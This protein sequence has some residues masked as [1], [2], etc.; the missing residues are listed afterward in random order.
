MTTAIA[1]PQGAQEVLFAVRGGSWIAPGLSAGSGLDWLDAELRPVDGLHQAGLDW[2]VPYVEPMQGVIDRMAGKASVIRSFVDSW[3]QIATT[4]GQAG[5]RL[6]QKASAETSSWLGESADNYRTWAAWT[7]GAAGEGAV[8]ATATGEAARMMGEVAGSARKSVD[9]LVTNLVE[10]LASAVPQAVAAEGGVTP[11]VL[12]QATTLVDSYRRPVADIERNLKTTVENLRSNL[13]SGVGG[14][15]DEGTVASRRVV[16][17]IAMP[18]SA[19]VPAGFK[20]PKGFGG[21]KPSQ[22]GPSQPPRQGPGGDAES[23]WEKLLPWRRKKPDSKN[24]KP[25]RDPHDDLTPQEREQMRNKIMDEYKRVDKPENRLSQTNAEDALK[26][27]PPGTKIEV[28]GDKAD[29][30]WKNPDGTTAAGR[31]LKV[32]EGVTPDALN[33]RLSNAKDQLAEVQGKREVWVQLQDG[34]RLTK[35]DLPKLMSDWRNSPNRT[36]QQWEPY[37]GIEV[38]FRDAMGR[39]LGRFDAGPARP[40]P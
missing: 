38:T 13:V 28:G 11:N 40:I 39:V 18:D 29:I 27:G 10:T 25:G 4:L 19:V 31:E 17:G 5:E 3:Q 21:K 26:G 34:G 30:K 32:L 20:L 7:A 33:N 23:W 6:S 22:P 8:L 12:R 35:E 37:N 24:V 36:P 15:T 1:P 14:A 2:L 9:D 16:R